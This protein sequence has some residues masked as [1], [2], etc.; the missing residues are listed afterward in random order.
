MPAGV[1]ETLNQRV[2]VPSLN[3][4]AA[5]DGFIDSS[6]INYGFR[7]KDRRNDEVVRTYLMIFMHSSTTLRRQL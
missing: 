4:L 7:L 1:S 3:R 5:N 2:S 6:I